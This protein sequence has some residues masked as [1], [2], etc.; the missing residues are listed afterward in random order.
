MLDFFPPG[1][2]PGQD[3]FRP[4][5]FA[6]TDV[7][8]FQ[9]VWL[10]AD[11]IEICCLQYQNCPGWALLGEALRYLVRYLQGLIMSRRTWVLGCVRVDYPLG[12]GSRGSTR[13]SHAFTGLE[14]DNTAEFSK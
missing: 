1:S 12:R 11:F 7:A 9:D 5:L 2:L 10:S 14:F 13:S 4:H 3:P 6:D 8:T